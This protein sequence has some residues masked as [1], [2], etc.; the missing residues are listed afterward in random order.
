MNTAKG[1]ASKKLDILVYYKRIQRY[2][3]QQNAVF[4]LSLRVM[5][6]ELSL[7]RPMGMKSH[8]DLPFVDVIVSHI[9]EN[10]TMISQYNLESRLT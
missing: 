1:R 7:I 8:N 5:T 4:T 10:K 2:I 3:I 9:G 6:I